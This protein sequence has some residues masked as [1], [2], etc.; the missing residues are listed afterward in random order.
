MKPKLIVAIIIVALMTSNI[1]LYLQFTENKENY[2]HLHE[3]A[4]LYAKEVDNLLLSYKF[5][6]YP[7]DEFVVNASLD[8]FKLGSIS[9]NKIFVYYKANKCTPCTSSYIESLK[10]DTTYGES[11]IILTDF[12]N[13][14]EFKAFVQNNGFEDVHIYNLLSPISISDVIETNYFYLAIE[15][16]KIQDLFIPS[17]D[18]SENSETYLEYKI[19]AN[20]NY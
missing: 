6:D 14:R 11:I 18:F 16:R 13:I 8:T 7:I 12:V 5:S 4:N 17:P 9:D 2:H 3:A 20:S 10:E 15:N 1:I 19:L